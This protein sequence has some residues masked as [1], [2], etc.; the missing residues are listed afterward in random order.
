MIYTSAAAFRMALEQRLRQN[1]LATAVP[2]VRLR[3]TVAFDRLLARLSIDGDQGW[4][5]KGG[6]ALQLMFSGRARTTKDIDLHIGGTADQAGA[7]LRQAA[8]IDLG[9][10]FSFTVSVAS[11]GD[12]RAPRFG[13]QTRVDGRIWEEFHVDLGAGEP[14]VGT[15]VPRTVTDLLAFADMPPVAFPCYPL[16][17]QVAEKGRN[18]GHWSPEAGRWVNQ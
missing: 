14:M 15:P 13:V 4:V 7:L 18:H 8:L 2:L 11:A 5:L 17:Q 16:A 1:S 6:F 12:E 3:K 10:F 9:D